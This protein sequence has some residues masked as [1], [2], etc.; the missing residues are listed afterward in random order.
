MI[1]SAEKLVWSSASIKFG[2]RRMQLLRPQPNLQLPNQ[3]PETTAAIV[4][5]TMCGATFAAHPVF[6][7]Q[8]PPDS[9]K[10]PARRDRIGRYLASPSIY[11]CI[12]MADDL[13]HFLSV[14]K[15][16]WVPPV[17][18]DTSSASGPCILR[19]ELVLCMLQ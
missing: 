11:T 4:W 16:N 19:G 15:G 8:K 6:G 3:C 18:I 7:K 5:V 9:W 17:P 12:E 1:S 2:L 13:P 14:C 10:G